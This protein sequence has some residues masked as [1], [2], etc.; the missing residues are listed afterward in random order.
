MSKDNANKKVIT[1]TGETRG[2]GKLPAEIKPTTATNSQPKPN[3][4]S[5]GQKK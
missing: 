4:Q 1:S 3:P 2:F 5:S